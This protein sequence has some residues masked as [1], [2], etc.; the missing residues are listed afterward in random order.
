MFFIILEIIQAICFSKRFVLCKKADYV[1]DILS[2]VAS[3]KCKT[4]Q[5]ETAM[6]ITHA[7]D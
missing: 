2:F 3:T 6:C 7:D 1:V 5:I 4:A